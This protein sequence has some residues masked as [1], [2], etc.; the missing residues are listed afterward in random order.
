[1]LFNVVNICVAHVYTKSKRGKREAC[2]A[3]ALGEPVPVSRL[4]FEH[5]LEALAVLLQRHAMRRART[6]TAAATPIPCRI[7]FKE[8]SGDDSDAETLES[9]SMST[10]A[11][12]STPLLAARRSASGSGRKRSKIESDVDSDV[13]K[14]NSRYRASDFIAAQ[15][16]RR[17]RCR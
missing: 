1:M 15:R 8:P 4:S 2:V 16:A 17:R 5:G 11:A 6:L 12:Q 9:D 14:R 7:Q 13:T 3:D 10:T